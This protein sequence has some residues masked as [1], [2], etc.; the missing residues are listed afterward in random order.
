MTDSGHGTTDR[1]PDFLVIGAQKC[2]TTTLYQD[3]CSH[4]AIALAD[5]ES[6]ILLGSDH[7]NRDQELTKLQLRSRYDRVLPRRPAGGL[8]GEVATPYAML[9]EHPAVVANARRALPNAKIIYIVRE[10][11]SRVISHHHHDFSLGLAEPDIN[12]AVRNHAALLNNSRYATQIAPWLRHYGPKNVLVLRFEDYV[13]DRQTGASTIFN[14]L[15]VSQFRLPD[16]ESVYNAADSKRVG[17]GALGRVARSK[18]YRSRVRP[19]VSASLRRHTSSRLLPKAPPRPDPPRA[20][21]VAYLV[22]TLWPE[23]DRLATLIGTRPWWDSETVLGRWQN[24]QQDQLHASQEGH[25]Q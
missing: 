21:T 7:R 24:H 18:F 5:K 6:S 16:P 13:A 17:M 2:G 12:S 1:L 19:F 4:P 22:D 10:P 20:E 15:G 8:L 9:P 11:V 25:C 14:F 23:V 3:L